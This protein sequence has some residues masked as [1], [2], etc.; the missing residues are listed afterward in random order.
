VPATGASSPPAPGGTEDEA[1]S[2]APRPGGGQGSGSEV[3]G[4]STSQ[5]AGAVRN[6]ILLMIGLGLVFAAGAVLAVRNRHRAGPPDS[7]RR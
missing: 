7:T 2:G 5:S 3:A 6:P 4:R 1:P